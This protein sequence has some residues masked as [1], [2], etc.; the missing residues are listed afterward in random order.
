MTRRVFIA[1]TG[2]TDTGARYRVTDEDGRLLVANT[3]DPAFAA[4]RALL[5][6]GVTGRLEVWRASAT[7]PAMILDIERAALLRTVET[8]TE[9]PKLAKWCP[10]RSWTAASERAVRPSSAEKAPQ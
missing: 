5:A 2:Y 1:C 8:E 4:A 3:R 10:P 6:K 7:F 9:G